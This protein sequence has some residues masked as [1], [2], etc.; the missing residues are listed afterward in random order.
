MSCLTQYQF[1]LLPNPRKNEKLILVQFT[2]VC[3]VWDS[4][5]TN[6]HSRFQGKNLALVPLPTT[7]QNIIFRKNYSENC[8]NEYY[9]WHQRREIRP[10]RR[11][12]VRSL[13]IILCNNYFVLCTP[14]GDVHALSNAE[15]HNTPICFRRPNYGSTPEI[16]FLFCGLN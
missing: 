14:I 6:N 9:L 1:G 3:Q 10:H 16:K 4:S 2:N 8:K 11:M 5:N 12:R 15:E 13:P 7:V